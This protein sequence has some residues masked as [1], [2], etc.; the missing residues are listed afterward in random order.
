[1]HPFFETDLYGHAFR[2][3]ADRQ[4]IREDLREA[5]L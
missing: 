4:R 5:G 1:L 2:D 3:P